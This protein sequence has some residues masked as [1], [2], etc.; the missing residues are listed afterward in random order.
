MIKRRTAVVGA[1][2]LFLATSTWSP[3]FAYVDPNTGG[4]L[5]QVLGFGLAAVSGMILFFA[6]HIRR[7]IGRTRRFV[8]SLISR[9]RLAT[10]Q[11]GQ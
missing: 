8:K 5:F 9:N 6:S 4:M 11:E 2:G 7:A 3:V 1:M 10:D